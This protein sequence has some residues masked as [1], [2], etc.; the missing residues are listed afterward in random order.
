MTMRICHFRDNLVRHSGESRNPGF[1]WMRV[2][3]GMTDV[4]EEEE[5]SC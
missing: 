2:F 4:A 5:Q 1:G 3:T